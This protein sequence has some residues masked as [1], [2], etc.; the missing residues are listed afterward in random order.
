MIKKL[1]LI[2]LILWQPFQLFSQVLR[3][4]DKT[5]LEPLPFVTVTEN[6][7][8]MS[9]QT[10]GQGKADLASF[11][12][13]ENSITI[14]S[15]GYHT[16]V[17]KMSELEKTKY[18]ILLAPQTISLQEIVISASKFEEK[19]SD[20]PAQI[21]SISSREIQFQNPATSADMLS[22]T[23]LV[24]V[25]KSQL[26]GGSPI[27][28]GFEAN[29]ILLVVDG[30]R[31]NNAI[32]RGGHLQ[33]IITMDNSV[34]EKTEIV[35]GPGSVIYGSDALGGVI[36]FHTKKPVLNHT[37]KPYIA[38]TNAFARYSSA[39]DENT[40]HA[41]VNLG[42]KKIASFTSISG[43]QF[44]DLRQGNRRNPF[45][46]DW[47]K[48]LFYV[49]RFGDRDSM[50]ANDD[51]NVQIQ[52]GYKQYDVL[53]KFLFQPG[54][55]NSHEL[56]FQYSTTN[57]IPRYDRLNTLQNG[58]PR[59][60]EWYYGPQD[61][62]MGAYTF[63]N[64][65]SG[66][67]H[68]HFRVLAAYQKIE[69]SRHDRRFNSNNLN[70]RTETVDVFSV[71]ADVEKNI[72]K[73]EIRYGLE[74]VYNKVN[75]VAEREH[76]ITGVRSALDTRY[77]DGGS[78]MLNAAFFITD[79]WEISEK[80]ILSGGARLS[81]VKLDAQFRDTTFFPFPFKTISQE[82]ISANG[83]AGIVVKAKEGWNFFTRASSGFRAPNV[84]DLA[85]VFES[86]P[87]NVVVPNPDLKP[88]Y[89]YSTEIGITKYFED[90]L[91]FEGNAYYAWYRDAI[92]TAPSLFA[93]ADSIV[94]SG[95]LSR[96]TSSQNN[97]NAYMYGFSATLTAELNEFFTLE[98]ALAYSYARISTDSTD[99]PLDHIPPVS[100]K[101]SIQLNL[102]KFQSEFS[103][104][105]NGWKHLSDYNMFGEDNFNN[106]TQ[107][108]NPA[109]YTL[110]LKAS[111]QVHRNIRIQGAIE[112]ILDKNYRVFASG[113][114]APGRN[115][116]F[117]VRASL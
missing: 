67:F 113:I 50:I 109:W 96:V 64:K 5:T 83:H 38:R 99:Y 48:R 21:K 19:K 47:G 91:K 69:E 58:L 63:N 57:D 20:V 37:Y 85:K 98:S 6:A 103:V 97:Q 3:V 25:Q 104:Y 71:N 8:G 51:F 114:S 84:D 88:E 39:S 7:S 60:A 66:R 53:Q 45:Y 52:S 28:R 40:V 54:D 43:S 27:M 36:H 49:E 4:I 35:F 22:N 81:Y 17:I 76:K 33:N 108:G 72:S 95:Q 56:N 102:K 1:F 44:G 62:I 82:N 16:V 78:E 65:L 42:W 9:V 18:Q 105:Y 116:V 107:F 110:N 75:S 59:F 32:Y 94:Y 24:T 117:T 100:G 55:F 112:N 61:R 106:A 80:F 101:T 87:G 41:D 93:G 10:D 92:S 30:V 86:V 73:H 14:F 79:Q 74:G 111:Y 15:M 89:V 13:K 23:G 26:G 70:H 115:Y 31:M 77:P 34:L 29:K 90:K 46:G 2:A 12:N 68:D 11:K